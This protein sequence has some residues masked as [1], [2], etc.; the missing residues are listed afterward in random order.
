M[1]REQNGCKVEDAKE[2]HTLRREEQS[3]R[4]RITKE[5]NRKKQK[6]IKGRKAEKDRR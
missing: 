3:I 1:A 2:S 6:M 4:E 5:E